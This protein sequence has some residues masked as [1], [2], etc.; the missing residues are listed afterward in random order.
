LLLAVFFCGVKAYGA[1][2]KSYG[3]NFLVVAPDVSTAAEAAR[4]AEMTRKSIFRLLDHEAEWNRPARV[5]LTV[6]ETITSGG[7]VPLWKVSVSRGGYEGTQA[8]VY[9]H[10]RDDVMVLQVVAMCLEDIAGLPPPGSTTATASALPLWLTCGV[11]ENLSPESIGRFQQFA[12]RLVAEG[13]SLPVEA[14]FRISELPSEE[15]DR[16]RFFKQSGSIVG[17]LLRQREGGAKLGRAIGR[18]RGQNDFGASLLSEFAADFGSLARLEEMWKESATRWSERILG[19]PKMSLLETKDALDGVLTVNI[20]VIDRDT[21]EESVISTD[22]SGLFRHRNKTIVQ[23]IAW[24]K[25]SEVFELSLRARGEYALILQ[26][27]FRTLSAILKRDRRSFKKHFA[28]A[29]RLRKEL[30]TSADFDLVGMED[31]DTSD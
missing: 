22:L 25:R 26:E 23:K 6:R 5:H 17:F 9:P 8:N 2:V 19:G 14:F 15:A 27:Y 11:A 16:E 20:P 12:A 28:S 30:E 7:V 18:F 24:D 13:E 29:E 3:R 31:G 10:R 4:L 1:A 21:L